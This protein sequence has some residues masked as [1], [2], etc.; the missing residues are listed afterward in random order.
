MRQES[1][2][3]NQRSGFILTPDPC[4]LT[5]EPTWIVAGPSAALARLAPLIEARRKRQRVLVLENGVE[6]LLADPAAI[7]PAGP[8]TVLVAGPR[9]R[10]PGTMLPGLFARNRA[11]ARVSIGWIPDAGEELAVFARAAAR[12]VR[13]AD[14]WRSLVVLGQWED[15]FLRVS[16]R[17]ARWFEK[18]GAAAPVFQWTAER[19]ARENMLAGLR[20]GPGVAIYFGHGR[21]NG[22]AGYHGVRAGHFE[23][24]WPEPVGALLAVCCENASRHRAGMSF[25]ERL[26]LR[27][28]FAGAMAAVTKTRHDHNRLWGPA[29]CEAFSLPGVRTLADLVSRAPLPEALVERS[30]YRFIGD[31]AA[32]LA[33]ARHAAAA[34]AR[35]SAPAADDPLPA[36]EASA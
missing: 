30:P 23:D 12:A 17:T 2:I 31:P 16:L 7:L 19:I 29:L 8:S 9:R 28:V 22:W 15:R 25:I 34:A 1:G 20:H 21:P 24:E 27:G 4:R 3:R 26:A 14:A 33:G 13:R 36:W 32:P 35:V 6:R 18:H 11:G 10:S 5:P